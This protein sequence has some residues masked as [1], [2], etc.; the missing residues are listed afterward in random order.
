MHHRYAN[1]NLYERKKNCFVEL[2]IF[3]EEARYPMADHFNIYH[4]DFENVF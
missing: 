1:L 3:E 4:E 2:S